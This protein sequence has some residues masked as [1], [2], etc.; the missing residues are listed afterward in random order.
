VSQLTSNSLANATD[1]LGLERTCSE[2]HRSRG[3]LRL[4]N[5]APSDA[6]SPPRTL[7]E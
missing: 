6:D 4:Q 1:G 2:W 3:R 7:W 5:P